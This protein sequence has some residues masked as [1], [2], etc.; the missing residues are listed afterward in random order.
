MNTGSWSHGKQVAAIVL[1]TVGSL[2]LL[3]LGILSVR[4]ADKHELMDILS[5][6]QQTQATLTAN[7]SALQVLLPGAVS[8]GQTIAEIRARQQMN[9][10][11]IDVLEQA[12]RG[13]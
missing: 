11:R 8:M 9:E 7:V 10:H 6:I 1:S 13:Q 3:F 2:G 4:D 12:R 5:R